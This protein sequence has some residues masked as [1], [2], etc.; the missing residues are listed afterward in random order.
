M[1]ATSGFAERFDLIIALHLIKGNH[2]ICN[3]YIPT[4]WKL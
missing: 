1:G 3:F 4:L 2:D